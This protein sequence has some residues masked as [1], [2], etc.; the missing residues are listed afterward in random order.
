MIARVNKETILNGKVLS[1]AIAATFDRRK[2]IL[3]H[4]TPLALSSDFAN[5]PIK[6]KQWQAFLNKNRL[7]ITKTTL[8]TVVQMIGAFLLP[9]TFAII[10]NHKFK[11]VWPPRGP[12]QKPK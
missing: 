1:R 7:P 9:P 6:Q 11:Q 3:P 2:T 8:A 12:W 10:Q 4:E 5:D